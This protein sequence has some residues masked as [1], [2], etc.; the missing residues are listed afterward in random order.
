MEEPSLPNGV[1][2]YD[3]TG[4]P[5]APGSVISAECSA[6]SEWAFDLATQNLTCNAGGWTTPHP[7]LEGTILPFHS[8]FLH[9]T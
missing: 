1:I 7:C 5:Y 6:G 4:M 3:N 9:M 8:V 2:S